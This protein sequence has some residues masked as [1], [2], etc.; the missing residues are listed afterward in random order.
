MAQVNGNAP[1]ITLYTNH[2]CPWAHRAHVAIKELGLPYEEVIIDLDKPRELWYL[3]INPRGL[4]PAIDF[5]GEIITE[6][7]IVATFLADAYPSH[8][9]PTAGTPEA[10]LSRAKINF[11]VDTWFSKANSYLF[12]ILLAASE[13]DQAK[14]SKEVVDIVG[15]EIEPLLKDAK[16][17]FG[18]S[19]KPTLAEALTAPFILRYY[20]FSKRDA[21]PK[22]ILSGFDA[23]PNFS[24]WAAEVIK[25]DS[26]TY[27]WNEEDVVTTTLRKVASMKGQAAAK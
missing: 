9:L 4:V 3:E 19:D 10:A 23:L 15:K 17:F 20:T 6:S 5:N 16:P 7:G 25:L 14:M 1:K 26:V 13:E 8:L 27:I 24:K 2:R 18:G 11:F 12:K 22:S 21:L